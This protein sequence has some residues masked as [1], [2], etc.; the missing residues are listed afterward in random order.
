MKRKYDRA[1]KEEVMVWRL[2]TGSTLKETGEHFDV[3]ASTIG[4]WNRKIQVN[5][6]QVEPEMEVPQ[7][8]A[9]GGAF[10]KILEGTLQMNGMVLCWGGGSTPSRML[11]VS[12]KYQVNAFHKMIIF[13]CDGRSKLTMLRTADN[14]SIMFT[15]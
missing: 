1:F 8:V 5:I 15:F 14:D 10:D 11:Q 13:L 12:E 6:G 9:A 7:D 2:A 4:T 3:S